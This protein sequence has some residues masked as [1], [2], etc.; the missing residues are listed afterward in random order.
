MPE[1]REGLMNITQ[2][3]LGAAIRETSAHVT[4]ARLALCGAS[5]SL[6]RELERNTMRDETL[7]HF[8]AAVRGYINEVAKEALRQP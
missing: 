6:W 1:V 8:D 7:E 5:I 3:E 4:M 2:A